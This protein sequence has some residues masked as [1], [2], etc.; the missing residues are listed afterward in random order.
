MY[1][2][3]IDHSYGVELKI[4]SAPAPGVVINFTDIPQ[5]RKGTTPVKVIGIQAFTNAQL[6]TS[7]LGNPVIPAADA[8]GIVVTFAVGLKEDLFK[9]PLSD[10]V[11]QSNSGLIR[12]FKEKQINYT[13][14]Y[15]TILAVGGLV[16]NQSVMFNFI[17]RPID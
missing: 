8:A 3:I 17:Y 11:S 6:T 2:P 1:Q 9:I 4:T 15:I 16:Q 12:I 5:L 13:K 14:S 10:L 7:P